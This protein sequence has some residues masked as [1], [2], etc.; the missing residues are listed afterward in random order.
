[1]RT[2]PILI[3][4]LVL[5]VP[6][7]GFAQDAWQFRLT[8][9]GWLA[10]LKG[11]VGTIPGQPAVGVDI[12]ASDA[13]KDLEG[14]G[15]FMLDA[16]KGR[17]GF[18]ADFMYTDVRSDYQLVPSPI[19]LKLRSISKTTIGT[20]AYQ[21][22]LFRQGESNID[23]LAGL[24]YWNVD[25]KLQFAGGLGLLAGRNISNS[26]SWVDPGLGLKGRAP[27]GSSR[28]YAEGAVGFGGLGVGS[29]HF[30]E[31]NGNLGYQWTPSI[32]TTIGYRLFDVDYE[33]SGFVYD[34]RQQGWQLGFTWS[35]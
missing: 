16:R 25:S 5:A 8:P 11:N 14:G 12:S 9:Y 13:L 22:E 19:N 4:L 7:S 18:M 10:G 30:Y 23:V 27:L 29:D 1:M 2:L 26:E 6:S 34:V 3:S 35:F 21:Y 33:K 20:L 32:G 24:R 15:M 17:H 31:F 28:F